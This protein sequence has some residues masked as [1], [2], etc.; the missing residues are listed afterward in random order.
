MRTL[1]N[2]EQFEKDYKSFYKGDLEALDFQ[3]VIKEVEST[4]GSYELK[5]YESSTGCGKTFKFDEE[6][7]VVDQESEEYEVIA[8]YVGHSNH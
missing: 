8:T 3:E 6:V 2:I 7:I 1:K 5:R 4:E